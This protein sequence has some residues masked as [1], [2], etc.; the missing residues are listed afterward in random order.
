MMSAV[1]ES[2]DQICNI[3]SMRALALKKYAAKA[4]GDS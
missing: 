1:T 4:A 3:L 2:L